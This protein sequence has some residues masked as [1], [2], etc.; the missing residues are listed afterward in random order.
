M[1]LEPTAIRLRLRRKSTALNQCATEAAKLISFK[2]ARRGVTISFLGQPSPSSMFSLS[3]EQAW[4]KWK[5]LSKNC[6][7]SSQT[8]LVLDGNL[9]FDKSSQ[10][11]LTI[12]QTNDDIFLSEWDDLSFIADNYYRHPSNQ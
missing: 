11:S 12:S 10:A 6:F 7:T 3:L 2:S 5:I 4:L 9:Y 1:G 8:F